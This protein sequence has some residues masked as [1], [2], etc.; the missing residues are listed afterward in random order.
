MDE[1]YCPLFDIEYYINE[2]IDP[3]DWSKYRKML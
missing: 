1:V 3:I 2:L